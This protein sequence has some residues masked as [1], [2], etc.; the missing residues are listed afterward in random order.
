LGY[1]DGNVSRISS[2]F[3]VGASVRCLRD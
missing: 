3:A 2:I 1:N